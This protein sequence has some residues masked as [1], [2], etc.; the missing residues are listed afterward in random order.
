[1]RSGAQFVLVH[2]DD[3]KLMMGVWPLS[4]TA[5]LH[6]DQGGRHPALASSSLEAASPTAA[7]AQRCPS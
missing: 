7:D 5:R 4:C 2:A 1:M 6:K 3:R